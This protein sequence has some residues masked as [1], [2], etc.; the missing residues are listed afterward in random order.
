[1][2]YLKSMHVHV[3]YHNT[4]IL[5]ENHHHTSTLRPL[6]L[7]YRRSTNNQ[8]LPI[9]AIKLNTIIT[10]FYDLDT[11]IVGNRFI[12]TEANYNFA[13]NKNQYQQWQ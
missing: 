13:V 9:T 7:G 6:P 12:H 5:D 2:Y 8:Q 4:V 1:M 3:P 11:R 10:P